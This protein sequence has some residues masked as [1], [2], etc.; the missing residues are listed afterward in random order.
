MK[1]NDRG[2]ATVELVLMT[3]VLMLII[4]ILVF[5]GKGSQLATRVHHAAD[6]GARAASMVSDSKMSGVSYQIVA[7]DLSRNG[8]DC[9]NLGVST[10]VAGAAPNRFVSVSVTCEL[11]RKGMQL[12]SPVPRRFSATSTEVIDRYRADR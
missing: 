7:K 4:M 11:A 8:I 10:K 12:F 5:V 6:Q 9:L 2:S 3:P 1:I